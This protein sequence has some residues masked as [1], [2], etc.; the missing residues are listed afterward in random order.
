MFFRPVLGN[1]GVASARFA[2]RRFAFQIRARLE[3]K[4]R[5]TGRQFPPVD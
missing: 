1:I 4:H 5:L 3:I 2:P